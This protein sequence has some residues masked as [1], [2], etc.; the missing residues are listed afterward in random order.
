VTTALGGGEPD[1]VGHWLWH[2][3]SIFRRRRERDAAALVALAGAL[4]SRRDLPGAD[5][6]CAHW[7]FV[8]GLEPAAFTRVVTDPYTHFW[9]RIAF[10]LMQAVVRGGALPASASALAR[11][12]ACDEPA[13]LLSLQLDQWKRVALG[14]ALVAGAK[15]ELRSPLVAGPNLVLPGAD[16][17]IEASEP[18]AI[19]GVVDGRVLDA[20]GR[21]LTLVPCPVARCGEVALPL[22]AHGYSVPGMG[23]APPVAHADLAFQEQKRALVERGLALVARH[24]PRTFAQI[25]SLLRW[26]AVN[27]VREE[28]G[29][30][31]A[32]YSELPG[33]IAVLG[34]ELAHVTAS[35]T[36]HELHHNRLFFLEELGPLLEG[37]RLG[38]YDEAVFYS[39][40]RED[41]RPL[42]GLLHAAYV[43]VPE[44][45]FWLDVLCSASEADP[46]H[47]LAR[48]RCSRIPLQLELGLR[49]LERHGRFT[50]RGREAFA[51]IAADGRALAAEMRARVDPARSQATY[52]QPDGTLVDYPSEIDGRPLT[53]LR[54]VAEHVERFDRERQIPPEWL[55]EL[56]LA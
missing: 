20:A 24:S 55:L 43:Y 19:A 26:F 12:L 33:A 23:W 30:N 54:L 35:A 14:A 6:F 41:P 52:I 47:R 18:V 16:A 56:G 3:L 1:P 53:S 13:R 46:I 39:P 7:A 8:S 40:W 22:Q 34:I 27:P 48:D 15:L 5:E 31:F 37:D 38:T 25:P 10:D 36:V 45:S 17:A 28:Y 51:R 50:P 4:A 49:Q 32:S 2:D 44:G 42:R 11:D 21:A 9:L 29:E